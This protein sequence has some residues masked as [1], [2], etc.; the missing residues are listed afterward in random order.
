MLHLCLLLFLY[1]SLGSP[2]VAE[3]TSTLQTTDKLY[4]Q[5]FKLIIRALLQHISLHLL[6]TFK[7]L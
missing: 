7:R 5:S 1:I 4:I 2:M 6:S 3:Q